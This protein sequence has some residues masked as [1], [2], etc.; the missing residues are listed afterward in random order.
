MDPFVTSADSVTLLL[1]EL[2]MTEDED[3][4][5]ATLDEDS[6]EGRV[7]EPPSSPQAAKKKA[8]QTDAV[9]VNLF[10]LRIYKKNTTLLFQIHQIVV[11]E[12]RMRVIILCVH[13]LKLIFHIKRNCI[14]VRINRQETTTRFI[15]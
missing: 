14:Q 13:K 1:E 12:S 5:R 10:I 15:V 6:S 7:A 4:D 8:T 2:G 9:K 11:H 3:E